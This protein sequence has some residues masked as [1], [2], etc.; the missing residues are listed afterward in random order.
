MMVHRLDIALVVGVQGVSQLAVV[1]AKGVG[2]AV[3]GEEVA[4]GVRAVGAQAGRR[5]VE[6][7]M[8]VTA[9]LG[10]L[11]ILG[12]VVTHVVV[13]IAFVVHLEQAGNV[14]VGLFAGSL[15]I[16]VKEVLE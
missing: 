9:L 6:H 16:R 11:H 5:V 13:V 4:H 2:C 15:G 3:E 14:V 8:P 12:E 10:I 1:Q 7:E